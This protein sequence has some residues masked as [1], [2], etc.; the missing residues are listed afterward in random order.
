MRD[1]VVE[2]LE[3]NIWEYE[4]GIRSNVGLLRD[5]CYTY[6]DLYIK[7]I[8]VYLYTLICTLY[9]VIYLSFMTTGYRFLYISTWYMFTLLS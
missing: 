7:S 4:K 5:N 1:K 8:T 3:G 6:A 2:R 9:N